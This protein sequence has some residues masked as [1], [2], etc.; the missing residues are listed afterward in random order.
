MRSSSGGGY[1]ATLSLYSGRSKRYG[2]GGLSSADGRAA[3]LQYFLGIELLV[4]DD[5]EPGLHHLLPTLISI[6]NGTI[7]IG[8]VFVIWRVIVMRSSDQLGSLGDF[9]G[10]RRFV[11]Q[12]PIEVV[13][14]NA[15]NRLPAAVRE[16][17]SV[18]HIFS[19][20]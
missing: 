15:Q 17:E 3:T 6:V 14:G 8:I 12:L 13:V 5:G 18:T 16:F 11:S 2:R 20:Y 19:A 1:T 4:H 9:D 10:L 7:R